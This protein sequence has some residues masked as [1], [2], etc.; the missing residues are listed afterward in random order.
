M[1]PAIPMGVGDG[2]GVVLCPHCKVRL[3]PRADLCGKRITCPHCKQ[4]LILPEAPPKQ[5]SPPEAESRPTPRTPEL[6][7]VICRLCNTRMYAEPKQIGT[8]VRCPDCHVETIV[9][10]RADAAPERKRV[11]HKSYGVAEDAP[12]EDE[13]KE[14]SPDEPNAAK[15][16]AAELIFVACPLCGTRMHFAAKHQGRQAKCPDCNTLVVVPKFD[17]QK[18]RKVVRVTEQGVYGVGE[19][20]VEPQERQLP[21]MKQWTEEPAFGGESKAEALR[22]RRSFFSGVFL[23]PWQRDVV[24][25]WLYISVGL[26]VVGLLSGLITALLAGGTSV[27]AGVVGVCAFAFFWISFLTASYTVSCAW[28]I[29]RDTAAG[30]IDIDEWPAGNWRNWVY[31]MVYLLFI[32][33]VAAAIGH[34][35]QWV[36]QGIPTGLPETIAIVL[37]TPFLLLS[38][39]ETGHPFSLFSVPLLTSLWRSLFSWAAYYL[40]ST[41]LLLTTAAVPVSMVSQGQEFLAAIVSA[42]ILGATCLILPRLLG[43]LAFRLEDDAA[44]LARKSRKREQVTAHA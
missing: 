41:A 26:M 14:P 3:T 18:N 7:P 10:P 42:P 29:L 13:S 37:L 11:V 9:R 32:G 38:T 40:L 4:P 2:T 36:A 23:F 43:R 17:P 44:K 1:K 27:G 15:K 33:S 28:S 8:K 25:Q 20:T 31:P 34:P 6:I 30:A 35:V 12:P 39:L 21:A 22:S 19:V 16:P 24:A 5:T